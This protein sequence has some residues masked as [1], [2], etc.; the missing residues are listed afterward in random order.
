MSVEVLARLGL[1]VLGL[2]GVPLALG[3]VPP[4]GLYGVRTSA[5]LASKDIWIVVNRWAGT[6]L[7]VGAT[8]AL[9]W[10]VV[11]PERLEVGPL[12]PTGL[13]LLVVGGAALASWFALRRRGRT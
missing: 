4:N 9:L 6:A 5:T 8:L 13:P 10:S 2:L 7:F 12:S 3:W 1:A 11:A